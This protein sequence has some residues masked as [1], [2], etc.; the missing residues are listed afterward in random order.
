MLTAKKDSDI[1]EL[2][3]LWSH[4][5]NIDKILRHEIK[6]ISENSVI[7][8]IQQLLW[9]E[10]ELENFLWREDLILIGT[11]LKIKNQLTLHDFKSLLALL[12][13]RNH[14]G[15]KDL[16]YLSYIFAPAKDF[17]SFEQWH[18]FVL[19]WSYEMGSF[20]L[21]LSDVIELYQTQNEKHAIAEKWHHVASSITTLLDRPEFRNEVLENSDEEELEAVLPWLPWT[22]RHYII[23]F[24]LQEVINDL[25]KPLTWDILG[26]S[27]NTNDSQLI[28]Q[29][30]PSLNVIGEDRF[31]E[32][33]AKPLDMNIFEKIPKQFLKD[34]APKFSTSHPETRPKIEILFPGGRHIGHSAVLIKTS[35]G[36]ILL[37][38]GMSVVNNSLSQ[39]HPLYEKID[40]IL[41]THA[42]TDHAGAIPLLTKINP[43]LPWFGRY[44][45]K[46]MS[47]L[48][49]HNTASL[50]KRQYHKDVFR[51]NPVLKTLIN[52]KIINNTIDNFQELKVG[53]SFTP[54]PNI[55]V[56]TYEA[57]HI[58]GAI[59]YELNIGGKRILYTG[60]FNLDGTKIFKETKF[61]TDI[62]TLI[63]DG[64]NY[65]RYDN[66]EQQFGN[67]SQILKN[68]NRILIPAFSL[69]RSQE[70]L[71]QLRK[72]GAEKDYHI[73]LTGMGGKIA[74]KLNLI[75][76][77]K[78]KEQKYGFEI[79]P[80]VS[81]EQFTDKTIVI[82]G[83]G[84]LQSGTARNLLDA[85]A[86][87]TETS[88]VICG[89]QAP[90]TLGHHLLNKHPHLTKKYQQNVQKIQLSGH[91]SGASLDRYIDRVDG[92][93]IMVHAP[94][95]AY[96]QH[97]NKDLLRPNGFKAIIP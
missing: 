78:T 47:E 30:P 94:E 22:H 64:T 50:L 38:F 13:T 48:L 96:E 19:H 89:F 73:Y 27:F 1:K 42:H 95:G 72:L 40:L 52:R 46:M 23:D 69:G 11:Y 44:E 37:D 97:Q 16:L 6:D 26:N 7:L 28:K 21:N 68:S 20:T 82:A 35:S 36:I 62:D 60:D 9:N 74:E 58:W 87:D 84:M 85:T 83:Q 10:T 4:I 53:D 70:M 49:W 34:W 32:L 54:L 5:E 92:K 45:T 77:T 59:G 71:Y 75:P 41:A 88:V 55:E 33:P 18:D 61:P 81:D 8:T 31:M 43:N 3:S 90:N 65:G 17:E 39:W 12:Y 66:G 93:K 63:F 15:K 25:P 79:V 24:M 14:I 67:L 57:S 51:Q 80:Y 56:T 86:T 2:H 91:T 76:K 29:F